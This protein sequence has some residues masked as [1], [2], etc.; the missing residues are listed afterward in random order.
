MTIQHRNLKHPQNE[1]GSFE[2]ML[3]TQIEE[4]S[5]SRSR[6]F[7]DEEFA[8]VLYKGELRSLRIRLGEELSEECYC[9]IMGKLLPKRAKLRTMNM[10]RSST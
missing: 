10:L 5:K 6:I 4:L 2:S 1:R 9:R 3:I 8:F 7:I